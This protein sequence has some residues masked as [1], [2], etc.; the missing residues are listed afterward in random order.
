VDRLTAGLLAGESGTREQMGQLTTTSLTALRAYLNGQ[1]AYRRGSY[2]EAVEHFDRALQID[3]SFALAALAMSNAAGWC[4]GPPQQK[5][6][7][8]AWAG[9]D[10]LNTRDRALL[11]ATAG[12]RYPGP[13]SA[14]E[15]LK[16]WE[17][18]VS[19]V[20]DRPEAWYGLGD[21]LFHSGPML[22]LSSSW[23]RAAEAFRRALQFDST[24]AGPLEHVIEYSARSGDTAAARRLLGVARSTDSTGEIFPYL[25]WRV[26]MAV[27]DSAEVRR[28]RATFGE[29]KDQSL[30]SITYTGQY[31]G[32]AMED[33]RRTVA[34]L[35]ARASTG[36][37][38]ELALYH[39]WSA[40]MNGGRPREGLSALKA[41]REVEQQ[42]HLSLYLQ[43]LDAIFWGGDTAAAVVAARELSRTEAATLSKDSDER[44]RQLKDRCF[45]EHW[46]LHRGQAA[47][48]TPILAVLRAAEEPRDS[49]YTVSVA[50]ICSAAISAW[51]AV[52]QKS[53][54]ADRSL[55]V[56]D[57]VAL[58]GPPGWTYFFQYGNLLLARLFE[59]RG[60]RPRALAVIRRR[61]YFLGPPLY[62]SHYLRE[63]ARL[64]ATLGDRA[65]AI[66]A[67][68]HY[69][70][71]R[72]DPETSV[73]PEVRAVKAELARLVGEH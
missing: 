68:Q 9:R 50:R 40:A 49:A 10:R 63:E 6:L 20:P 47:G 28:S 21:I 73:E 4:C 60:D 45:L 55:A 65:G 35:Q 33:V 61:H 27:G 67:Y 32:L 52:L 64:A 25:R 15:G 42:P 43:I 29:M 48:G 56:F 14:L 8:L 11:V 30:A 57:S 39:A 69:L 66:Q 72:S 7:R 16:A 53:P 54:V 58:T 2:K 18:A 24:F 34:V 17:E 19:A 62:L 37:E 70:A 1:A 36:A 59:A 51:Q 41:Y 22:A 44:A 12:P 71:L 5:G 31:D 26:A 23:E 38:R 3:S 46:R 13:S